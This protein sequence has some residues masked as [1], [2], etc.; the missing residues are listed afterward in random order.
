MTKLLAHADL[1]RELNL[2]TVPL[3]G[4]QAG[5]VEDG[6]VLDHRRP[7]HGQRGGQRGRRAVPVR[8]QQ[9]EDLAPGG[10]GERG[11]DVLGH[12]ATVCA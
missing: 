4:D 7:R 1:P 6:Q 8:G 5:A 3:R 10:I 12:T 2:A 9:V 11:E